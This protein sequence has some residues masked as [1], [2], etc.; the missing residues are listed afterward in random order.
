ML[1][2]HKNRV[3]GK[4]EGIVEKP[5][6]REIERGRKDEKQRAKS[7]KL[8]AHRHVIR[9][10]STRLHQGHRVGVEESKAPFFCFS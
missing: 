10:M 1:S 6:S 4:H 7:R 8:S 9:R 2:R 5:R 3:A